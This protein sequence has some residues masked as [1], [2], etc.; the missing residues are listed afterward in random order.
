MWDNIDLSDRESD[1]EN[2]QT[3]F[4]DCFP[5]INIKQLI[6]L[7]EQ[8]VLCNKLRKNIEMP[9]KLFQGLLF[10][11]VRNRFL[12]VVPKVLTLDLV[13][14]YHDYQK[15]WHL[16]KTKLLA[17]L[18]ESFILQQFNLNYDK[19][20]QSCTFCLL[21][22]PQKQRRPLPHGLSIIPKKPLEFWNLDY[23]VI[24]STFTKYPAMLTIVDPFSQFTVFVACNDKQ[25]DVSFL[26]SFQQNIISH[27]GLPL[28]I[29]SDAQSTLVS[30]KVQIWAQLLGIEKYECTSP[31]GNIAERQNK[32]ILSVCR[33][34]T[35]YFTL[36][37]DLMPT[38]ATFATLLINSVKVSPHN[39]SPYT[40]VWGIRPKIPFNKYVPL[41][42]L[43][44][45]QKLEELSNY[46]KLQEVF[47][48]I[49]KHLLQRNAE[50]SGKLVEYMENIHVSDL[51]LLERKQYNTRV[52][53]KLKPKFY[54]EPFRVV[55]KYNKS[56]L[57][58]PWIP[59]RIKNHILKRRGKKLD[60]QKNILVNLT[61][62]KKV[63]DEL[64][65]IGLSPYYQNL[66]N[67]AD[68]LNKRKNPQAV[69]IVQSKNILVKK[70]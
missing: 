49:R 12:L 66:R 48:Q 33:N 46:Q 58:K 14:F 40:L 59:L 55:K 5:A 62:L 52:G 34:F 24:N 50:K 47:F 65:V 13:H 38:V 45:P 7:Q 60:L 42:K 43:M 32:L 21:D 36:T 11:K 28:G 64:K 44:L 20:L 22:T 17:F 19:V 31:Q 67:L 16:K 51:V 69:Q 3:I 27:Y 18:K 53:H 6:L 2:I 26:N 57:I 56:A 23:V 10:K 37:E 68:I 63:K 8:D 15:C 29:G 70:N 1:F 35:R 39:I 30:T 25:T 61:R 41:S 9:F 4:N 54:N